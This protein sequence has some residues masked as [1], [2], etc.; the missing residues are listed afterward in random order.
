MRRT[1]KGRIRALCGFQAEVEVYI[2]P[3]GER[4]TRGIWG[5]SKNGKPPKKTLFALVSPGRGGFYPATER[6]RILAVCA[7]QPGGAVFTGRPRRN[8]TR[9]VYGRHDGER[10]TTGEKRGENRAGGRRFGEAAPPE[11]TGQAKVPFSATF[12]VPMSSTCASVRQK[13][14]L[15][16]VFRR[17]NAFQSCRNLKTRLDLDAQTPYL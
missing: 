17:K 16:T 1:A 5:A 12:S 7:R 4:V 2:E 10:A 3:R 6:G 11:K 9:A 14:C 8:A 15:G 13:F